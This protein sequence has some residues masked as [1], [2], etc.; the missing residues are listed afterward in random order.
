MGTDAKPTR[1]QL[2][3]QRAYLQAVKDEKGWT[4]EQLA[5]KAGLSASTVNRALKP[6]YKF[7]YRLSTIRALAA[8]SGV[9]PPPELQSTGQRPA[10]NTSLGNVAESRDVTDGGITMTDEEARLLKMFRR[11]DTASKAEVL[12]RAMDLL[13]DHMPEADPSPLTTRRRA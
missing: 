2:E 5:K 10:V 9:E 12:K 13:I 11:L 1:A 3:A 8:A 7:L 4:G 6:G